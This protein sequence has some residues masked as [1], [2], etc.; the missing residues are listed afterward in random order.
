MINIEVPLPTMESATM[1]FVSSAYLP[2][3]I[4]VSTPPS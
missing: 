1:S 3:T 2:H 4:L